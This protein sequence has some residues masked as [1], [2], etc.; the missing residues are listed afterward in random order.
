MPVNRIIKFDRLVIKRNFQSPN[1]RLAG[2]DWKGLTFSMMLQ[3]VQGAQAAYM[4]KY[5]LF[6]D[7]DGNFNRGKDIL[8]AWTP[9]NTAS[10]I[11]RLT[12]NDDNKNFT[13][14]STWY[15][16]DA[17]Y[18]RLKNVTI[19]Y[20]FSNILRKINHF[21]ERNSS[22]L[23]YFSGENL[24]TLTKYSGMD[25]ECGGWDGLKYPVSRVLSV[26]VKLTY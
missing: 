19:G 16:E 18:I 12:R 10:Y 20:D 22:C 24:F 15:L 9:E 11:P 1:K 7:G 25:P 26:G 6:S 2:F 21:G 14:P 13:T 3:G 8:N 5:T 23:L 17:S 4:A